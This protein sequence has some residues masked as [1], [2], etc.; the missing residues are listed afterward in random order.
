MVILEEG[1]RMLTNI[2]EYD[3]KALHCDQAVEV[4]FVKRNDE[5]TMPMF[6][7]VG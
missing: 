3:P 4:T 6:K 2:V 7:P 1:V 5:F